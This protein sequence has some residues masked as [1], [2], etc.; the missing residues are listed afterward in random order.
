MR[1]LAKL[2]FEVDTQGKG[3][4][5]TVFHPDDLTRRA[6]VPKSDPVR[7]GTLNEILKAV[8]VSRSDLAEHL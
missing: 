4:H 7:V 6:T 2:G 1:A 3:S 8:R 5:V